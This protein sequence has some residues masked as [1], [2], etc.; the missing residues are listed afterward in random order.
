MTKVQSI[1]PHVKERDEKAA[2]LTE[3]PI[4]FA[5]RPQDLGKCGHFFGYLSKHQKS[6][7]FPDEC[8]TCA[9]MV[10]CLLH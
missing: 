5:S 1:R 4:D 2:S 6:T 9:R 8:L 10:E 3:E 7:P